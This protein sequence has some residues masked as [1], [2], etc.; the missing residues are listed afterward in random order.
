MWH[1]SLSLHS[2][3][4]PLAIKQWPTKVRAKVEREAKQILRGV[5][6]GPRRWQ[7]GDAPHVLHVRRRLSDDEIATLPPGPEPIDMAGG[8]RLYCVKT[9]TP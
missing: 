9:V 6:T 8:G 2:P 5:G 7:Y 3:S 4:G 1:V